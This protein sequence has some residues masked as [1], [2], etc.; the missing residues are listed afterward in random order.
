MY[1]KFS[2]TLAIIIGLHG[3]AGEAFALEPGLTPNNVFGL[4]TNVNNALITVAETSSGYG[5]G[6]AGIATMTPNTFQGKKPADVLQKSRRLPQ[7]ARPPAA[8]ERLEADQVQCRR[9]R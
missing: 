5:E 6:A 8:K 1:R 2:F 4:W 7:Q 3:A 9:S